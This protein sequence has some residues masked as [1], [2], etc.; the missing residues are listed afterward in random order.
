M[1]KATKIFHPGLADELFIRGDAPMTKCE[2]RAVLASKLQVCPGDV[3]WD[4]GAGTGSVSVEMALAAGS[5]GQVYA[6]EREAAACALIKANA[7]K[8]NCAIKI[9]T[10]VA[11]E[12]CAQLPSPQRVFIGGSGG[13]LGEAV[14]MAAQALQPGGILA[15]DFI[16]LNNVEKAM[17]AM[18][19]SGLKDLGV[20]L[21][22]ITPVSLLSG[23]R[24]MLR[25]AT[26][27]FMT[28]GRKN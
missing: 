22:G 19:T 7:D 16:L 23:G 25:Q 4:I 1:E 26:P 28:W 8:F 17:I 2:V 9:I 15:M 12:A 24:M 13:N 21:V 20:V 14:A 18:E 11:P 27:V 10:G 3:C 5:T 6:I